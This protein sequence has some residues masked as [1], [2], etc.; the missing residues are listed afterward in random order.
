MAVFAFSVLLKVSA[1]LLAPV[2]VLLTLELAK[3][4]GRKVS[5]RRLLV[6]GGLG[7]LVAFV[8]YAPF[9]GLGRAS[10]GVL[11]QGGFYTVSLPA[12]LRWSLQQVGFMPGKGLLVGVLGT[13]FL[14][15]YVWSLRKAPRDWPSLA[16][17]GCGAYFL[18]VALV[19]PQ[20]HPWYLVWPLALAPFA[21]EPTL[22]VRLVLFSALAVLGFSFGHAWPWRE[23]GWQGDVQA[24]SALAIFLPPLMLPSAWIRRILG[25]PDYLRLR[26]A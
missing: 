7:L 18:F 5:A 20:F 25:P 16:T 14:L 12:F 6:G 22:A 11:E 10:L 9:G 21:R 15:A 1:L 13:L 24:L 3:R 23:A 8:S 17:V 4:D 2:Y 19:W 26:A